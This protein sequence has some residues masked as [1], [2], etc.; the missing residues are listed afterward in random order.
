MVARLRVRQLQKDVNA[1]E[2]AELRRLENGAT[3]SDDDGTTDLAETVTCSGRDGRTVD[4]S[5]QDDGGG[6]WS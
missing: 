3:A 1:T 5:T 6:A 4:G 2:E